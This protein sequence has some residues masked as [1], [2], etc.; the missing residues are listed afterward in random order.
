MCFSDNFLKLIHTTQ[1]TQGKNTRKEYH[2]N[3]FGIDYMDVHYFKNS[4]LVHLA[5]LLL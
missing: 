2:M 3:V 1:S 4:L 5:I